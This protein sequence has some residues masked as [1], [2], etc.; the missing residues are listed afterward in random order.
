MK[1]EYLA[2]QILVIQQK[3]NN[4]CLFLDHPSALCVGTQLWV[5]TLDHVVKV[6]R[7][8]RCHPL[9]RLWCWHSSRIVQQCLWE[10]TR[11]WLHPPD[12]SQPQSGWWEKKHSAKVQVHSYKLKKLR[13]SRVIYTMSI[14]LM[15][16]LLMMF[17]L[18]PVRLKTDLPRLRSGQTGHKANWPLGKLTLTKRH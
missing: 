15:T 17:R 1:I 9:W 11:H 18:I 4:W 10:G 13:F 6:S 3:T 2:I 8:E 16:L 5:S 12:R 14:R 7:A